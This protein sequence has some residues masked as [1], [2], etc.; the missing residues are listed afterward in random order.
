MKHLYK[1]DQLLTEN[2]IDYYKIN[3]RSIA[4]LPSRVPNFCKKGLLF[5]GK[6]QGYII[7]KFMYKIFT[8]L[9]KMI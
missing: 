9:T 8:K 1:L 4:Y 6:Y 5:E 2:G 3:F 7:A